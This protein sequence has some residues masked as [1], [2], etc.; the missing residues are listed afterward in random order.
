MID[1][2]RYHGTSAGHDEA[3]P[4]MPRWVKV[5]GTALIV[6]VLAAVVVMLLGGEDHGPGRHGSEGDEAPPGSS[7]QARL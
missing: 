2:P 3:P 1:P 6:L 5:F 7:H 4:R